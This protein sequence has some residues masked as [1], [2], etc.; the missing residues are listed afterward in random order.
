MT[1]TALLD[2]T[3]YLACPVIAIGGSVVNKVT[4]ILEK[5][6]L[7]DSMSTERMS[8]HHNMAGGDRRMAVWGPDAGGTADAVELL[9]A[10]GLLDRFLDSR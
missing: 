2:E 7:R 5:E 9:I 8:I 1:D 4:A 6:L 10:S 3:L